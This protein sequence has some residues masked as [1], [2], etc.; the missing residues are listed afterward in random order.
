MISALCLQAMKIYGAELLQSG[1]LAGADEDAREHGAVEPSGI[2]VAQR[3]VVA[4]EQLQAVG[5]RVG[6]AVGEAVG[7]AAFDDA[8]VDEV[9]QVS[10]EGDLAQ[11]HDDLDALE[12]LDLGGEVGGTL[13]QLGGCGLVAGRGAADD[14]ADPGV[15]EPEAVIAGVALGL[16]GKAGIM[17]YRIHEEAGSISRKGPS[18]AVCAVSSRGQAEDENAGTRVAEAGYGARPVGLVEVGAAFDL[19]DTLTISSQ[20]RTTFAGCDGIL[21]GS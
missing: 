12:L 17:E 19:A 18:C 15:A 3:R 13:T 21:Y 9:G 7:R 6:G 10:V 8:L 4:R 20:T 2:G 16:G 11:A 5:Q 14:G 1:E